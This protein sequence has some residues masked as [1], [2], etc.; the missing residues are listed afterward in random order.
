MRLIG[1]R[2][3]VSRL[4][5]RHFFLTV[6]RTAKKI[7]MATDLCGDK[8]E[9]GLKPMSDGKVMGIT[10]PANAPAPP[11]PAEKGRCMEDGLREGVDFK[12]GD[13]AGEMG[14]TT[15]SSAQ[16]CCQLCHANPDCKAFTYVTGPMACWLKVRPTSFS[17]TA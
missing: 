1:D 17:K 7:Y 15:L 3:S 11:A 8:F 6:D 16:E 13:L 10:Q 9:H 14:A 4:F 5:M 2:G 12:G